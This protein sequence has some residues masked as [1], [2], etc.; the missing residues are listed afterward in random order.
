MRA[1]GSLWRGGGNRWSFNPL[2]SFIKTTI[3][4]INKITEKKRKKKKKRKEKKRKRGM[5]KEKNNKHKPS[6]KIYKQTKQTQTTN[7]YTGGF[8]FQSSHSYG[9][10]PTARW[11]IIRP[12]KTHNLFELLKKCSLYTHILHYTNTCIL[13]LLKNTHTHT[14]IHTYIHTQMHTYTHTHTHTHTS[15]D[16]AS[17]R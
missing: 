6:T 1:E 16:H 4:A 7:W 11:Y 13:M 12:T 10:Q 2:K 8:P 3:D 17:A 5:K 15:P 14:N 9:R